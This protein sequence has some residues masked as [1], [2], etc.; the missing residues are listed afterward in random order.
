MRKVEWRKH[1][2]IPTANCDYS[3]DLF[4][5]IEDIRN[6][7]QNYTQIDSF[8]QE[9]DESLSRAGVKPPMTNPLYNEYKWIGN[10]RGKL[11]DALSKNQEAYQNYIEQTII[12]TLFQGDKLIKVKKPS[13]SKSTQQD[14]VTLQSD[15]DSILK[16]FKEDKTN[17]L[18]EYVQA[19]PDTN[20]MQDLLDKALSS[21]LESFSKRTLTKS[22]LEFLSWRKS[23]EDLSRLVLASAKQEILEDLKVIDNSPTPSAFVEIFKKYHYETVLGI[24]PPAEFPFKVKKSGGEEYVEFLQKGAGAPDVCLMYSQDESTLYGVHSEPSNTPIFDVNR[25][26]G[27]SLIRHRKDLLDKVGSKKDIKLKS[28]HVFLIDRAMHYIEKDMQDSGKEIDKELVGNVLSLGM[29]M[30]AKIRISSA[31]AE[32][33]SKARSEY[34][35][36]VA[37]RD[38]TVSDLSSNDDIDKLTW[39]KERLTTDLDGTLTMMSNAINCSRSAD[40]K[41]ALAQSM[42]VIL[43]TLKEDIDLNAEGKYGYLSDMVGDG[44]L[45]EYAVTLYNSVYFQK[46]NEAELSTRDKKHEAELSSLLAE[47][48]AAQA[49]AERAQKELEELK[50]Q[51]SSKQSTPKRNSI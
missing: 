41:Q 6:Q 25:F 48:E 7:I 47:K 42:V 32:D 29:E 45:D 33:L 21:D 10:D 18:V 38:M 23:L 14:V 12:P 27:D 1:T 2:T 8:L 39:L 51:M 19:K 3:I 4:R 37:D 28:Q 49:L 16:V 11:V 31:L 34:E 35:A 15:I 43:T 5:K 13:N 50:K 20:K 24:K 44:K 9:F 17:Y 46:E 40:R 22:S 36:L 30:L 26:E